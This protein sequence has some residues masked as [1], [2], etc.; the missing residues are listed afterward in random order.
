MLR[1]RWKKKTISLSA[2]E[3]RTEMENVQLVLVKNTASSSIY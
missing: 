2:L 3:E 1:A